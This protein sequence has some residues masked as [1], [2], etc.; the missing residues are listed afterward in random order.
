MCD[1]EDEKTP[2]SR[3]QPPLRCGQMLAPEV[4]LDRSVQ[5]R[6]GQELRKLYDEA[7]REPVPDRLL[8]LID[9]KA[10]RRSLH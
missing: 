8:A 1:D 6:I 2:C 10:A 4:K 9:P 5:D 7:L 3:P